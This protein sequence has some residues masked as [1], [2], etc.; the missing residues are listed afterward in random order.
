MGLTNSNHCPQHTPI[1]HKSSA[2]LLEALK[3]INF[4]PSDVSF[5]SCGAILM[6]TNINTNHTL[7]KTTAFPLYLSSLLHRVPNQYHHQCPR[8]LHENKIS[9]NSAILSGNKIPALQWAHCRTLLWHL[10]NQVSKTLL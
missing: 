8:L 6:Y 9:S 10:G 5:F 7:E 3:N 4:D 2:H 1:L